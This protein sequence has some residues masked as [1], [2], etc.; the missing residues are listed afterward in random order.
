MSVLPGVD[1][2]FAHSKASFPPFMSLPGG[3]FPG[4]VLY[5]SFFYPRKR[6]Q[7]RYA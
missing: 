3:L 4:I 5:L 2:R 7:M 1:G 6:L